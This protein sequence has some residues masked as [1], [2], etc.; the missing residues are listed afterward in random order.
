MCIQDRVVASEA[1]S[2]LVVAADVT[3]HSSPRWQRFAKCSRTQCLRL[4]FYQQK[5]SLSF[6]R[7]CRGYS[8]SLPSTLT[9]IP[10][11]SR[12]RLRQ[13]SVS[14]FDK[15]FEDVRGHC[16]GQVV[17]LSREIG[18]LGVAG[19]GPDRHDVHKL[20]TRGVEHQAAP[21]LIVTLPWVIVEERERQEFTVSRSP[22]ILLEVKVNDG[23]IASTPSTRADEV[24]RPLRRCW[25]R[26]GISGV[27]TR[28]LC[29]R[30][31]TPR[32]I[33]NGDESSE[34]A[35]K[36]RVRQKIR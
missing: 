36:H 25:R 15:T 31:D 20:K 4:F 33:D 9:S 30:F 34:T 7:E 16:L 19:A 24:G 8:E 10:S 14:P 12:S 32:C 18:P 29:L 21:V 13:K 35:G 28:S 6:S 3:A 22:W 17:G 27:I 1:S 23:T 26:Q 2:G 5:P 11:S